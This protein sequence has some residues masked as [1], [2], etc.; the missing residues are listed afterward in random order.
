MGKHTQIKKKENNTGKEEK[1]KVDTKQV[2]EGM[3]EL[4]KEIANKKYLP[5]EE[6]NKINKKLFENIMI[7]DVIMAFLYFISLGSLNI[8]TPIFIADLKVFSIGLIVFTIILFEISYKK[9]NGNLAIH[10]IECLALSIFV[11]CSIYL[12]LMY[13]KDFHMYVAIAAYAF[14]IYYLGK[15]I[16]VY[17]KMK[18]KYLAS[19][20]D[21]DEIIKK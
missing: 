10:G 12:Y 5:K 19:L 1:K 13:M 14:A 9:E 7:A 8:E 2:K 15:S 16:I 18:K 17:R 11:L 6:E 4:E 20:S 21:I 3:E